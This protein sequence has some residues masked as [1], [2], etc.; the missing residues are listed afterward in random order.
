[1]TVRKVL[2]IALTTILVA[3]VLAI[4]APYIGMVLVSLGLRAIP[5]VIVVVAIKIAF[6]VMK[7]RKSER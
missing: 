6:D 1:M 5:V 3:V 2:K 7:A 4:L